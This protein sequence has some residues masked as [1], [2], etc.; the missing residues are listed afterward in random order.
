MATEK[1]YY[2]NYV[3]LRIMPDTNTN[4]ERGLCNRLFFDRKSAR[5]APKF[6]KKTIDPHEI[7]A[8]RVQK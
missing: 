7:F 2:I 5:R 3:N 1:N 6:I 8:R 4:S